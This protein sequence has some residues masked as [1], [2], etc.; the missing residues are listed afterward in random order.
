LKERNGTSLEQLIHLTMS[1]DRGVQ[2]T[3]LSR[4]S[5]ERVSYDTTAPKPILRPDSTGPGGVSK[6]HQEWSSE[7]YLPP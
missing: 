5:I 7:R 2:L 3:M 1:G 6:L 4:W